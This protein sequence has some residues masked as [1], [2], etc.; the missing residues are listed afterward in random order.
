MDDTMVT[1]G[2]G[3]VG[4]CVSGSH[5]PRSSDVD[6]L[7]Y[8]QVADYMSDNDIK[9]VCHCA[10]L[11][12]GIKTNSSRPADF[13][14]ENMQMGL[15]IVKASKVNGVKK[16]LLLSSTCAF[17]HEAEIPFLSDSLHDGEPHAS[18]Y[19]YAYAKRMLDVLA[20]S[21]R[22]QYG[23]DII[24]VIP[25]NIYGPRD[26]FNLEESHVVPGLIHK[27]RIC[28]EKDEPLK[29]WG[30]GRAKR[31][32]LYSEDVG[33]ILDEAMVS[34]SDPEPLVI[35]PPEETSIEDLARIIASE[36]GLSRGYELD[37]SMPDGP[38]SKRSCDNRFKSLYGDMGLTSI[39]EG[40]ANTVNWFNTNYDHART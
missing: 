19:G 35:S 1:G 10:G 31:E 2:S 21:Y 22:Q 4:S 38:L 15:N 27:A 30:S 34:Y 16:V 32:F 6:L 36:S 14:H 23:M 7:D 12:G 33:R 26:N 5:K 24:S 11:V 28:K 40:I 39:E 20:R 17:P 37:K 9:Q 29:V 8:E 3:M 18:N 13:F 25:C